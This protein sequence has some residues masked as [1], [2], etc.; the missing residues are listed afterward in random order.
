MFRNM[1]FFVLCMS[2]LLGISLGHRD[3]QRKCKAIP[4]T[5]EWPSNSDWKRLNATLGGK[6][7]QPSA[8]GGVCH[9]E[10]TNYDPAKCPAVQQ[11]WTQYQFHQNDPVSSMWNQW[12]NDTCLPVVTAPCSGTGYPVYVINATNALD[13]KVGVD[14]G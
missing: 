10:Q 12:N 8:P 5:P 3:S 1:F 7:L 2:A 14:F 4:G 9:P 13:V 6:L 11:G